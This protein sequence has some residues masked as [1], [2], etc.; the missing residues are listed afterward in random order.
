MDDLAEQA[1]EWGTMQMSAPLL[2]QPSTNF[3]FNLQRGT[4]NYFS[5][6]KTEIQASSASFDQSS[7][8]LNIA[9]QVQNDPTVAA[10]FGENLRQYQAKARSVDGMNLMLQQVNE[11]QFTEALNNALA[12]TNPLVR[13]ALFS[14]LRSNIIAATPSNNLTY[15]T[16]VT[17]SNNVPDINNISKPNTNYQGLFNAA[18]FTAPFGL[19]GKLG[20]GDPKL[21]NRTALNIAAGDQATEAI[22]RLLGEPSKAAEFAGRQILFGVVTVSVNPGYRTHKD[23][24]ADLGILLRFEYRPARLEVVKRLAKD[25]NI[26][27]HVR[28][29]IADSYNLTDESTQSNLSLVAYQTNTAALKSKLFA[30]WSGEISG[31][32][33]EDNLPPAPMAMAVSPLADM[34]VAAEGSSL[35]RQ[36]DFGLS[37]AGV[38]RQAGLLAQAS[39]VEQYSHRLEQ[40]AQSRT[41]LAAINTYSAGGGLFGW[42]VGPRFRAM[43]DPGLKKKGEPANIL[44]RQTFPSLVMVGFNPEDIYPRLKTNSDYTI[45]VLE[46]YL[47]FRTIPRWLPLKNGWWQKRYSETDRLEASARLANAQQ[48]MDNLTN[49]KYARAADMAKYRLRALK[50][51]AFGYDNGQGFE[52]KQVVPL[53]ENSTPRPIL[54]PT[55]AEIFPNEIELD[56]DT[57]GEPQPRYQKFVV[58][59]GGLKQIEIAK[60]APLIGQAQLSKGDLVNDVLVLTT[61]I[62]GKDPIIFGLPWAFTNIDGKVTDLSAITP[63]VT[64]TVRKP[65]EKIKDENTPAPVLKTSQTQ[66]P[67]PGSPTEFTVEIAP[68]AS[69]EQVKTALLIV[70]S[71]INKNKPVEKGTNTPPVTI[72]Q[73]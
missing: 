24:A 10:A 40:D 2:I 23:Y 51:Q 64:I 56:A 32:L 13:Q 15:P 30:D 36:S 41:A 53:P 3:N 29:L 20:A 59:G 17:N 46:P 69:D 58:I 7:Q 70:T 61:K 11:L 5:E 31:A 35:R 72:P 27:E 62:T 4:S 55:V 52:P 37:L 39:A 14:N 12:E 57:K 19:L 16:A 9:L 42:Q 50:F 48:S 34:D 67:A 6:A 18:Q 22:F 49:G 71:D 1:E 47:A 73:K 28:S 8:S 38:L 26:P 43:E 44:D 65:L 33:Q 63:K 60:I 21:N 54:I 66:A 45:T 68:K 25:K